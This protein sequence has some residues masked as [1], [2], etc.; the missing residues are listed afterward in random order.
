MVDEDGEREIPSGWDCLGISGR[1][2]HEKPMEFVSSFRT[3][4]IEHLRTARS[5]RSIQL[6]RVSPRL[7]LLPATRPNSSMAVS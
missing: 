4:Y 7:G 6:K 1:E 5:R 3:Y 2:N